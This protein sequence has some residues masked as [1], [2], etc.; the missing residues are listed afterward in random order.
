MNGTAIETL[1]PHHHR[2]A[3][4]CG[5]KMPTCQVTSDEL[6]DEIDGD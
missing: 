2:R 4:S 6:A 1:A 5:R 3:F